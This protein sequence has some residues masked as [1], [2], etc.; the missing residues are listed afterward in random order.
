MYVDWVCFGERTGRGKPDCGLFMFWFGGGE[1]WRIS[2][3]QTGLKVFVETSITMSMAYSILLF[4]CTIQSL[5]A[6]IKSQISI[7]DAN[8]LY[9]LFTTCINDLTYILSFYC[10]SIKIN[11]DVF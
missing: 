5:Y 11:D 9:G 7:Y 10:F 6:C 2:R 3:I 4:L 1:R 8:K